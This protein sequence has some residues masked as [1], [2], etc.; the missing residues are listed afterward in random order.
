MKNFMITTLF[1]I[2]TL[3]AL[4]ATPVLAEENMT[5][6]NEG[7]NKIALYNQATD[8]ANE[9]RFDEALLLIDQA[10][11]ADE[12]FTLALT[13]KSGIMIAT[14]DYEGALKAAEKATSIRPDQADGWVNMGTALIALERYEESLSA[15]E[16]AIEINPEYLEAWLNKGTALGELGRYEEEL[17]ASEKA[18]EISP[19]DSRAW[20]NKKYAEN[21][22]KKETGKQDSPLSVFTILAAGICAMAVLKRRY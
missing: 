9:G 6:T 2:F 21:Q 19:K 5:M 3:S 17:E 13:T 22:I 7:T 10:I 18:I 8:L 20:A 15:S 1:L 14:G 4:F 11:A 12:N 16:K